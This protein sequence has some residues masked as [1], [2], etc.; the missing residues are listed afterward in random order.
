MITALQVQGALNHPHE[1]VKSITRAS[2]AEEESMI[3]AL[4]AALVS[5]LRDKGTLKPSLAIVDVSGS[6]EG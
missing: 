5:S 6:M 4:W 1:L 3:E 2:S